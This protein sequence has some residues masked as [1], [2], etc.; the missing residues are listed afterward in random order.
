MLTFIL[1]SRLVWDLGGL[2]MWI[3]K[4]SLGPKGMKAFEIKGPS[5]KS[6]KPLRCRIA[7]LEHKLNPLGEEIPRLKQRPK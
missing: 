6:K 4:G 7:D 1:K 3:E 5:E 2:I